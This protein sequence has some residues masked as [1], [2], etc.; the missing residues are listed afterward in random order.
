MKN[1]LF[2]LSAWRQRLAREPLAVFLDYDGT[3]S[4]IASTPSD[5]LLPL[6]T[7]EALED[8]VQME[9]VKVA[10]ISGRGLFDLRKLVPVEGLSYVGSHG[11]EF[12]SRKLTGQRVS[13]Q[14]LKRLG[15]LK[16]RLHEE[17][18]GLEGVL[19][20]SKPFSLAIHYRKASME[21]E[22]KLRQVIRYV[23]GGAL[24]KGRIIL[25]PGK[26]VVEI[27]PPTMMDKG[28]AVKSLLKIWGNRKCLPIFIGDD[29]TDEAAFKVLRKSGL[30][31]KV[32]VSSWRS[33]AQYFLN[34]VEDVKML[35]ELIIYFRSMH[36]E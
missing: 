20:E 6:T 8:L 2:N 29:R 24:E 27:M 12:Q 11:I 17:V 22:K 23:C 34:G 19:L 35:L 16:I 30:T 26:K 14:Y 33:K 25:M 28:R 21:S 18:R 9:N 7:R 10:I 32:G 13:R 3:L 4:A 36:A 15:E 1:L 31:V 5:A